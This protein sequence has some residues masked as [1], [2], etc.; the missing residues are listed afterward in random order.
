MG[1]T[2]IFTVTFGTKCRGR[3]I[4][5]NK[6]LGSQPIDTKAE[7]GNNFT[8]KHICYC[9]AC[10]SLD[11]HNRSVGR[12]SSDSFE[13]T[14][15][16]GSDWETKIF[17][18]TIIFRKTAIFNLVS[19]KIMNH[20]A[21]LLSPRKPSLLQPHHPYPQTWKSWL[22][23]RSWGPNWPIF[24]RWSLRAHQSSMTLVT[25]DSRVPRLTLPTRG[26]F[27]SF[28]PWIT[29]IEKRYT[30][31]GKELTLYQAQ[32]GKLQFRKGSQSS[33]SV[34]MGKSSVLEDLLE[35]VAEM[36]VWKGQCFLLIFPEL[37]T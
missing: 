31:V 5:K 19:Q 10:C 36:I 12:M 21:S 18:A 22:A 3:R 7:K 30:L 9:Y 28:D 4:N 23:W 37:S 2:H 14:G 1:K 6:S 25:W 27:V 13:K 34:P 15:R 35:G 32:T 33:A 17:W 20:K 8:P 16:A 11:H 24:P 29:L 26:A